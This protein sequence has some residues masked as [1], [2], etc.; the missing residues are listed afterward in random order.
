MRWPTL[1]KRTAWSVLVV[2]VV[3]TAAI[4]EMLRLSL[5]DLTGEKELPGL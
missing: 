4:W 3:L 1:L 2:T 5:P